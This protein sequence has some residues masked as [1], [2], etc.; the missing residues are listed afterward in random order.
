MKNNLSLDIDL[1][2]WFQVLKWT[3]T[4]NN[5]SFGNTLS[6]PICSN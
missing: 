2:K 3:N 1:T 6:F 5:L 4:A